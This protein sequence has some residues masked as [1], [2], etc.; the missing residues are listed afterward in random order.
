MLSPDATGCFKENPGAAAQ[1]CRSR[2]APMSSSS[3]EPG[4][5][6]CCAILAGVAG[7][8]L[9]TVLG[10]VERLRQKPTRQ[11]QFSAVMAQH[12]AALAPVVRPGAVW[13]LGD[14][15]AQQMDVGQLSPRA[16]NFGIGGDTLAGLRARL[17]SYPGLAEGAA[18]VLIIGTNDLAGT[19]PEAAAEAFG[20][21]LAALPP[22]LPLV[23][24]AV[25]PVDEAAAPALAG[26]NARAAAFNALAAQRCVARPGCRFIDPGPQMRGP[27]GGLA[28]ALHRGDGL[29]LSP[30]G[31]EQ[32]LAALR[33]GLA[34]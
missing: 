17:A 32:L 10:L 33:P 23:V 28:P 26:R 21:L 6:R 24:S 34:P 8:L 15:L 5:L 31:Y 30:A 1:A 29:H 9:L 20:A 18:A 16:V 11:A 2:P 3:P 4:R 12:L 7:L 22:R 27:G 25:L 13:V 14:S 19:T